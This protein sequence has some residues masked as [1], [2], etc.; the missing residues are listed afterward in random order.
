[1][2]AG[3]EFP[4]HWRTVDVST[5]Q[6]V[7]IWKFHY[8]I[9]G[10]KNSLMCICGLCFKPADENDDALHGYARYENGSSTIRSGA[11]EDGFYA[12]VCIW[13]T[14]EDCRHVPGFNK[15]CWYER[16]D[17]KLV[18]SK[19]GPPLDSTGWWHY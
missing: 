7:G 4:E 14:A 8:P 1:M 5:G 12:F 19:D 16:E 13:A 17:G 9:E 11:I 10:L 2:Q 15:N 3:Y 18:R 6:P